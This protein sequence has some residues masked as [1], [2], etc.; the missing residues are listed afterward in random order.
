MMRKV[1]QVDDCAVLAGLG[2]G[3]EQALFEDDWWDRGGVCLRQ[4]RC[5]G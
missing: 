4:G 2:H 1:F 3:V 5:R